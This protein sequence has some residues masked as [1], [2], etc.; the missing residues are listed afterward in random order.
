M[1]EKNLQNTTISNIQVQY[2]IISP[3]LIGSRRYICDKNLKETKFHYHVIF[4]DS[5]QREI[6]RSNMTSGDLQNEYD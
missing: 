6:S 1:L 5:R 2:I 3:T 4:S